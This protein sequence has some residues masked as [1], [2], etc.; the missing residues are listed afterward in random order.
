MSGYFVGILAGAFLTPHLVARV[1]H[2]RV[3]AALSSI[4]STVILLHALVVDPVAWFCLR[5]V[6]GI[7]LCGIYIVTESWLNG[8]AD[9][10]NRGRLFAVYMVILLGATAAAQ[11][12]LNVADPRGYPLFI[13]VSLL[14]SLSIVPILLSVSPAPPVARHHPVRLRELYRVSPLGTIGVIGSGAAYAALYALGPV[15]AGQIGLTLAG[16]STFMAVAVLGGVV[17]QWPIGRLSDRFDRRTVL[18]VVALLAGAVVGAAGLAAAAGQTGA[19]LVLFFVFGGLS[20][21]IYSLSVAH[22]NDFLAPEQLVGASSTVLLA[23]G[24]GAV[25][26]P[27]LAG[28]LMQ[29]LG[30]VGFVVFLAGVHALIGLFAIWRM[31]RRAAPPIE[32]QGPTII[33]PAQSTPARAVAQEAMLRERASGAT[34]T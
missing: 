29:L 33:L 22:I 34:A 1:G 12:L 27:N 20:L 28:P 19:V 7:A 32:A 14:L 5:V 21:P 6:T 8:R 10:E 9:N 3:F 18:T 25:L 30:V 4:A 23:N 15:Y 2:V 17:L 26:G 11:L 31:T 16:I 13:L 24:M